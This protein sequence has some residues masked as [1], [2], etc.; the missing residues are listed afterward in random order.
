[1]KIIWVTKLTDKD[2]FRSTQMGLSEALRKRGHEV[3]I[4]FARH[5]AEKKPSRKN[6]IYLPTINYRLLS[7]TIYG[8]IIFFYLPL[9][10]KKQKVDLII[11]D[12]DSIWSPF[13]LSLKLWKVPIIWD[14]RS[15][16]IDRER[17]ILHDISLYLS[18]YIV[19][20]F[21]TITT[22]FVRYLSIAIRFMIKELKFGHQ[23]FLE[24]FY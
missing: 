3:I 4:I 24:N 5:F 13:F 20:G 2:S 10:I 18:R 22:E 14:I 19:D 9:L 7:G 11:V 8:I 1:M 16:P 23:V 6:I 12:G 17:S 15:L 21:T